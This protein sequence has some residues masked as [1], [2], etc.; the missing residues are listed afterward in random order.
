MREENLNGNQ[1]GADGKGWTPL[2]LNDVE[3]QRSIRVHCAKK[4]VQRPIEREREKPTIGMEDWAVETHQ[5]GLGGVLVREEHDEAED[6]P[7]PRSVLG[8]EDARVPLEHVVLRHW[9]GTGALQGGGEGGVGEECV[10][11]RV[12]GCRS[13]CVYVC[14]RENMWKEI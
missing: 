13:V 3:T 1:N 6:S 2:I 8:P 4:I 9:A 12:R 14:D 11:V 10:R 7:V 5:R